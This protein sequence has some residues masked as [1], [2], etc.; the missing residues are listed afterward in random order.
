MTPKIVIVIGATGLVGRA[1]VKQLGSD[2]AVD[3]I[4]CLVRRPII[5]QNTSKCTYHEVSF[6]DLDRASHLFE[7]VTDVVCCV[8][9]TMKKAK[10]REQFQIVD[11]YIPKVV[12]R[13]A[14][15]Y[16]VDSYQLVSSVGANENSGSFY[17]RV[18]GMVEKT[19]AQSEFKR[20]IIYRPSLLLGKRDEFRFFEL[21]MLVFFRFFFWLV[22]KKIK[23]V[24]N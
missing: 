12:A 18:K 4:R 6:L 21:L 13:I 14:K 7:G 9:T 11:H 1:F 19:V 10:S 8:G 24:I 16:N 15:D 20:F 2:Q 23:T 17:L 5:G 22:P 3:E